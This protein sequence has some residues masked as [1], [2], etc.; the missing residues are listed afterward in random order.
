MAIGNKEMEDIGQTKETQNIKR[1]DN[2][3]KNNKKAAK[4]LAAFIFHLVL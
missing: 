4:I 2:N 1:D 3:N